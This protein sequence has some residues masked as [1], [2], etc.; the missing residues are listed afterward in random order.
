M[1]MSPEHTEGHH[2][3]LPPQSLREMVAADMEALARRR[4]KVGAVTAVILL[5]IVAGLAQAFGFAEINTAAKIGSVGMLVAG[6]G[7]FALAFGLLLPSG[8]RLNPVLAVVALGGVAT[9]MMITDFDSHHGMGD[10]F[11]RMGLGCLKGGVLTSAAVL[12]T[13]LIA[14]R[15]VLRRHAPTGLL[16]GLGAGL[17]GLVPVST[18]CIADAAGHVMLWH[19]LVPVVASGLAGL[20]WG[21]SRPDGD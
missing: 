14:G 12:I 11:W 8:R 16:L 13:A 4:R 9:L 7:L 2:E 20:L 19:T 17:L 18:H 6:F 21:L 10:D 1:K 3:L 5:A 15:K